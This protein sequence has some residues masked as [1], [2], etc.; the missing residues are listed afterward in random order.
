MELST[1]SFYCGQTIIRGLE[2]ND[3]GSIQS[4]LSSAYDLFVHFILE[5]R[6]DDLLT[7]GRDL[8]AAYVPYREQA[9]DTSTDI[10][11]YLGQIRAL[12][13]LCDYI[14]QRLV[15]DRIWQVVN[16]SK[17]AKPVLQT[18]LVNGGFLLQS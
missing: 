3:V 13:N 18:L 12:I 11:S 5:D 16:Q 15:P 2:S 1:S 7:L 14:S 8:N 4:G 10:I 9:S 17:Y 6:R